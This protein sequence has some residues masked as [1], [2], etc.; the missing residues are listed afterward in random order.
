M[1]SGWGSSSADRKDL[2]LMKNHYDVLMVGAGL[3]GSVIAYEAARRGKSALVLDR[4]GHIGGTATPRP[5]R[6]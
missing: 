5:W 3:F 4:R 2:M 1:T 6:G